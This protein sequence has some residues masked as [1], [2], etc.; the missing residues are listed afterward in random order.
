MDPVQQAKR[1]VYDYNLDP[2]DYTDSEAE[3]IV[4]KLD[5]FKSVSGGDNNASR[6]Y[7]VNLLKLFST[8]VVKSYK[9][10]KDE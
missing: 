2:S 9:E 7:L 1:I 3:K 5:Y 6:M 8:D 4:S 10:L